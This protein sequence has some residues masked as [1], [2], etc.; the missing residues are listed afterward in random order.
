MGPALRAVWGACLQLVWPA[1]CAG[2]NDL[3]ADDGDVFC[4]ACA[5]ALSPI[6]PACAVCALPR[7]PDAPGAGAATFCPDCARGGFA[8]ARA[9]AA[10]EYGATI[11]DAIVRMKHGDRPDLG[12]RLGRLFAATV[13][14][15]LGRA[16]G[17]VPPIDVVL[18]VPLHARRLRQRGFNQALELARAA[19]G[20]LAW[21]PEVAG[22]PE[23]GRRLE[24]AGRPELGRRPE[25]ARRL[26]VRTRDTRELGHL[27][28]AARRREVAG[29]FGVV[30]RARVRG[31]RLLLVDDVM[32]TGATLDGCAEALLDAGAVEVRV[33][34]LARAVG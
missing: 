28:P 30:D 33:A 7:P 6:G 4:D 12:R 26:L 27:G 24:L 25:L 17:P 11:A 15:A 14:R 1:R 9:A 34:V 16:G 10:F 21:R 31:Q 8:F 19:L 32:T 13:G 2:C 5:P 18:P 3:V 22:L 20:V 23:L 29:A